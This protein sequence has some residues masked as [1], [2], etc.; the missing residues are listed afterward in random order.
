LY[1]YKKIKKDLTWSDKWVVL[2]FVAKM[3]EL[4]NFDLIK[5]ILKVVDFLSNGE[6]IVTD[7]TF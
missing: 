5:D 7:T 2:N 1:L 3:F 4:S 6:N